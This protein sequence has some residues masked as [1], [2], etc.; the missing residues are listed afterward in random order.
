MIRCRKAGP[1]GQ[2][3]GEYKTNI[4]SP[5]FRGLVLKEGGVSSCWA[6]P[7]LLTD[8]NNY[9]LISRRY[10]WSIFANPISE[11]LVL[12]RKNGTAM[13]GSGKHNAIRHIRY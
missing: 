13:G 6:D 5:G 4:S 7:V 3:R 9:H 2:G 11:F 10:I 1:R 12:A 8:D